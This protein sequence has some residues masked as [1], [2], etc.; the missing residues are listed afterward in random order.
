MLK[1][2]DDD[3]QPS[4]TWIDRNRSNGLRYQGLDLH[5]FDFAA[6][7]ERAQQFN[8]TRDLMCKAASRFR[9]YENMNSE[10]YISYFDPPLKM[11]EKTLTD[12][13]PSI[14]MDKATWKLPKEGNNIKIATIQTDPKS[15]V[16]RDTHSPQGL[17][18]VTTTV[19]II[20]TSP[21]HSARELC[22]SQ[23]SWGHDFVSATENLF[24]DM[25]AKKLWP[26]CD[27]KTKG[28]CFDTMTSTMRAGNGLRGRD[29]R[30]GQVPPE[31]SYGKTIRWD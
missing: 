17:A 22:E 26:V 10:D 2:G 19:V 29:S 1:T 13:D 31:K 18:N 16:R 30:S 12:K 24:C 7:E 9:M 14:V 27:T 20:S 11:I 8:E 15:R 21:Q 3:Y 23:T 6:T 28:A 25:N 4:C 5:I